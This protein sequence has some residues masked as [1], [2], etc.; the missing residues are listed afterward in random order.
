[1]VWK[2]LN[3]QTSSLRGNIMELLLDTLTAIASISIVARIITYNRNGST[4]CYKSSVM[5]WFITVIAGIQFINLVLSV[6][7]ATLSSFGLT[8]VILWFLIISKGNVAQ[9]ELA[10]NYLNSLQKEILRNRENETITDEIISFVKPSPYNN[11]P[12]L[13]IFNSYLYFLQ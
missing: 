11:Y 5:A 1:M 3:Y 10:T 8:I 7:H 13:N 6:N 2:E 12:S 9:V 4:Y